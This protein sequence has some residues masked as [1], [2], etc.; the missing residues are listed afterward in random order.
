MNKK[1]NK[2]MK[3]FATAI[4]IIL[5][6]FSMINDLLFKI[7]FFG[8]EPEGLFYISTVAMIINGLYLIATENIRFL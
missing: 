2:S 5:F 3:K 1:E 6:I 7:E 4:T 8:L